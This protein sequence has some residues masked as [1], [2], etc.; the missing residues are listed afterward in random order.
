V[1]GKGYAAKGDAREAE[2][3][4][5]IA[6]RRAAAVRKI[7]WNEK[8]K[9]FNDYLWRESRLANVVTAAG[10]FPLY[11]G[12]ADEAQAHGAAATLR[13]TLLRPD[14]IVPT[15]VTSGQQWDAP[16]GWAPLVWVAIKGLERYGERDLADAIA[17]GW[18]RENLEEY[19]HTG[20]LTEKYDVT[21]K[22]DASGGE[23][24]N[25]DGFG[26]T[27]GILWELQCAAPR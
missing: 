17:R 10:L 27:N 1:I 8:Q 24:A 11:F 6:E 4:K 9:T 21:G 14:G 12:I 19:A 23:Y 25:Q 18:R 20:K 22:A 15:L 13:L 26:W 16:N 7:L 5:G 2:R 3:W